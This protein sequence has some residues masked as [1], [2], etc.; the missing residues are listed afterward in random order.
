MNRLKRLLELKTEARLK[1]EVATGSRLFAAATLADDKAIERTQGV[2]D[3]LEQVLPARRP[4]ANLE[5]GQSAHRD[6]PTTAGVA[7]N[8]TLERELVSLAWPIAM[9]M[10]GETAMGLVDTKLVG[11]LGADALGGVGIAATIMY[12][13]YS[14]VFG[15]M[16]GV[17][18][19]TAHAVGEGRSDD[20]FAY[21]KAGG[22]I[23]FAVGL[24]VAVIC[25]D[26]SPALRFVGIDPSVIPFARD[27]CAA[28]TL[29]AP[30]TCALAAFIQHRQGV[31]DARTT[32]VVGIGGNVFNAALAWA[33]IYGHAGLPALGVRGGG[34]AT[35]L[36]E[37]FELVV[38]VGLLYRCERRRKRSGGVTNA[39]SLPRAAREVA[40]LGV[41][42]GI[43]F[44]AEMLAFTTF[45][46][47]LG[48]IGKSEIASHQIA[49]AVIRVSF[50]PGVAIAEAASV[51]VGRALGR[52]A[53]GEADVAT[54]A[55]LKLAVGFMALCG[56]AFATCGGPLARSFTS[57]P[58]VLVIVRR[59][60]L[61]AALFQVLDAVNIVL[62]GALR[63]AKDVRVVAF[64]GVGVVWT[65]VPTAAFV[66]GK[67]LGL[68]AIG[69]WLGFV[70]ETTIAATLFW[71]RWSKGSWR[72]AYATRR[73]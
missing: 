61:V 64:I 63:G 15:L 55:A 9:A 25:R 6:P 47:V 45:T 4:K 10:L 51:M 40:S 24:A 68:G 7:A 59:L 65:C 23:G 70:L 3:L 72:T 73:P 20:A 43:Q 34:Y 32:M 52:K 36:T 60:L 21:A 2:G 27:F 30:A 50:L 35:S 62:R 42:T 17:K 13:F 71:R 48:G 1:P 26:V 11:G 44:G 67:H 49:L 41:P 12:L 53:L 29:G 39:L 19:R 31:G 14:L 8:Q 33:L 54:K 69:G 18:V 57:D 5:S 38:M 58:E 66:F 46:A 56:I 16:R 28:V 22:V 37:L